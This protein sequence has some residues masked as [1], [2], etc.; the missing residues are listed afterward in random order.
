MGLMLAHIPST[1]RQMVVRG[2]NQQSRLL[3]GTVLKLSLLG[4]QKL[5]VVQICNTAQVVVPKFPR[6]SKRSFD[7]LDGSRPACAT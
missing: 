7:K 3:R 5:T 1:E 2:Q 6:I 4:I